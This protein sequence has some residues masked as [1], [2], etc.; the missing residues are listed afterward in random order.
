[1]TPMSVKNM[2]AKE[3]TTFELALS[4][5]Q[6]EPLYRLDS[7]NDKYVYYQTVIDK[8]IKI[9]FPS[10]GVTRH[11]GYMPW[12]TDGHRLLIRKRQRAHMRSI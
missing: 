7:C 8:L 9:C 10:Y 11:T 1:M 4:L 3:N 6:W 12:I 5:I 2:G